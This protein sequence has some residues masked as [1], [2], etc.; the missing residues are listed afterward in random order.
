MNSYMNSYKVITNYEFIWFFH[1]WIPMFY[2]FIYEVGCT[3]VPD[4]AS[5]N[6]LTLSWHWTALRRRP[7]W[8]G[9]GGWHWHWRTMYN[10]YTLNCQRQ[11]YYLFKKHNCQCSLAL[12]L[13]SRA[14]SRVTN[15]LRLNSAEDLSCNILPALDITVQGSTIRLKRLRLTTR[16][17]STWNGFLYR[18]G[19][20]IMMH[21]P[22]C[23]YF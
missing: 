5:W 17:D 10:C 7:A 3:K 19:I 23:W 11:S 2:E 1:I 9:G 14:W 21:S 20:Y 22:L 12:H 6:K 4:D 15:S 16:L 13:G 18:I 8:A